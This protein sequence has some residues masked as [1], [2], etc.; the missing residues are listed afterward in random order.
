MNI[1][2]E[3]NEDFIRLLI[4][5]SPMNFLIFNLQNTFFDELIS[6]R[7]YIFK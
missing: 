1:S 2:H 5:P 3:E 7:L 6:D 4:T